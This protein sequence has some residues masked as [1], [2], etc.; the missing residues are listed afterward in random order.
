[1]TIATDGLLVGFLNYLDNRLELKNI[2]LNKCG[3]IDDDD[4]RIRMLLKT[5]CAELEIIRL[6]LLKLSKS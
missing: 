5:E 6:E 1:M 4:Y 2:A 3:F